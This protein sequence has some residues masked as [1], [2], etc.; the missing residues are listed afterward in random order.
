MPVLPDEVYSGYILLEMH[1]HE[2]SFEE[3][4]LPG[5]RSCSINANSEKYFA[6]SNHFQ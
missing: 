2:L 1:I 3:H 4:A 6:I 5:Q